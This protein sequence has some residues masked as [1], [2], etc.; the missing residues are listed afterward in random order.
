[1]TNE[2]LVKKYLNTFYNVLCPS[3]PNDLE[4][5]TS[6]FTMMERGLKIIDEEYNPD[7]V[8]GQTNRNILANALPRI[9]RTYI[10]KGK[11]SDAYDQILYS[12]L[13]AEQPLTKAEKEEYQHAVEYMEDRDNKKDYYKH[14]KKFNK[15][16]HAYWTAVNSNAANQ[17]ELWDNMK[18]LLIEWTDKNRYELNRSIRMQYEHRSPKQIFSEAIDNFEIYK[19]SD[20]FPA[21]YTPN[22]WHQ[23]K[24][25]AWQEIVINEN[26]EESHVHHDIINTESKFM[27]SFSRGF[28]RCTDTYS[29]Y[30]S[31]INNINQSFTN[32]HLTLKMKAATVQIERPW[33][34][35][36]L[37]DFKGTSIAN[38]YAGQISRGA[39]FDANDCIMPLL[40]TEMVIVKD[41]EIFGNFNNISEFLTKTNESSFTETDVQFLWFTVG[42]SHSEFNK[43]ISDSDKKKYNADAMISF[44]EPQIIGFVNTILPAYPE[45][46]GS[47]LSRKEAR[48]MRQQICETYKKEIT[49]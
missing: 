36:N 28:W 21:T 43:N 9:N 29:K 14:L 19:R 46:D 18:E 23:G 48:Q 38:M 8:T 2:E 10:T 40:P 25:L 49:E 33:F 3:N 26:T 20:T 13:P 6:L 4:P 7:T 44:K 22:N 42:H 31:E 1:M 30:T 16:K 39:L 12:V 11:V 37:M 34:K 45:R 35:S 15:A 41:V 47:G 32:T 24:S 5:P 27:Q 17:K